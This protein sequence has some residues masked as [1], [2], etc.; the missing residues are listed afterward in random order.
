[1]LK[2]LN[3]AA[4]RTLG[5]TSATHFQRSSREAPGKKIIQ[6]LYISKWQYLDFCYFPSAQIFALLRWFL[7]LDI[8]FSLIIAVFTHPKTYFLKITRSS[9]VRWFSS[10]FCW[11]YRFPLSFSDFTL[12]FT[13]FLGFSL[14][15]ILFALFLVAFFLP[16][17]LAA[18]YMPI[19]TV[20]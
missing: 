6:K 8:K 13:D 19:F 4:S 16:L 15:L 17:I 11:F 12:I 18:L 7:V 10:I 14:I 20:I 5:V 1:M 2:G 9:N 3:P